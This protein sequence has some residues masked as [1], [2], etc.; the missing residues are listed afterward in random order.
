MYFLLT[1][2]YQL[3]VIRIPPLI[4]FIPLITYRYQLKDL[5]LLWSCLKLI[6]MLI[7]K[8]KEILQDQAHIFQDTYF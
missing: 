8:L 1:F 5:I 3:I 2:V 6:V 7:Q 4:P